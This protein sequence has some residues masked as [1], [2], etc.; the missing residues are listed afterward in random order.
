MSNHS[1]SSRSSSS[2]TNEDILNENQQDLTDFL[3]P[4]FETHLEHLYPY[5]LLT[6]HPLEFARQ[7]TLMEEEL[8]KAIKPN[9]LIS[10]GWNKPDQKYKLSPN[11]SKLINLSNKFTYWYAKCIVDTLNI[12]ERVAVVQ[13]LLD[14]AQ[15]FYQMN[16]FSGLKEIYAAFETSSTARLT[17]TRERSG[18]EQHKMYAKFKQ[19]FDNHDKGYLDRLKKCSPPCIPFIGIHLTIIYRTHEY[20]K[21][22]IE[23]QKLHILQQQQKFSTNKSSESSEQQQNQSNDESS[24]SEQTEQSNNLINFSKYRLLVEF[25]NDLLQYQTVSYKFRVNEKI[26]SFLLEDIENYFEKAQHA[27]ETSDEFKNSEAKTVDG[28]TPLSPAQIVESWLFE[29]SRQIEPFDEKKFPKLRNYSLKPPPV[30]NRANAKNFNTNKLGDSPRSHSATRIVEKKS[31][32]VKQNQQLAPPVLKTSSSSIG[33]MSSLNKPA[34]TINNSKTSY[35]ISNPKEESVLH[36]R[37]N[38]SNNTQF[39]D[40]SHSPTL[41]FSTN[42]SQ[43]AD[44]SSHNS[45]KLSVSSADSSSSA[46]NSPPPN[47]DEVFDLATVGSVFPLITNQTQEK[48]FDNRTYY[49]RTSTSSTGSAVAKPVQQQLT[50]NSFTSN[51]SI[52]GVSASSSTSSISQHQQLRNQINVFSFPD[53]NEIDE[54]HLSQS[55]DQI[56]PILPFQRVNSI[57]PPLMPPPPVPPQAPGHPP[58]SPPS[59]PPPINR[60]NKPTAVQ[61]KSPQLPTPPSAPPPIPN[62]PA[63]NK[64]S[65]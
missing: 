62:R 24:P 29:K 25:V 28:L 21:L 14:I 34:K 41:V 58:P 12:E 46:P 50:E 20:N 43:A 47:Y 16:N 35:N 44:I 64:P 27:L 22:N 65:P 48:C 8:F 59:Q 49:Q 42:P 9:E 2:S 39:N 52:G 13:R 10:L 61:K 17:T 3:Y 19:L 7:A 11:V 4:P 33:K 40:S 31:N 37:S 15:Y 60:Q 5:E 57:R 36:K 54:S 55:L 51:S 30:S 38:S 56:S 1:A 53:F 23:N 45:K 63:R 18:L 26:R 32:Q 6:I